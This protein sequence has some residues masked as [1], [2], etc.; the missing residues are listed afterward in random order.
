MSSQAETLRVMIS[1]I[2][3]DEL[4]VDPQ[5]PKRAQHN[6]ATANES[7]SLSAL[8]RRGVGYL[9]IRYG[10]SMILSLGN[11]FVLT[12]W[13]GPHS[14]G[15]F[16]TAVSLTTFLSSLTR[17]GVDTYLVRCDPVPDL[18]QYQIASTLVFL[19]SSI[20]LL[21]GVASIPILEIWYSQREFVFPYLVLLASIPTI[22]LSGIPMAKLERD[23]N[24]RAVAGIEMGGQFTSLA[25]A[26][27][28][29][30]LGARVW[31]PVMGFV[32]WQIFALVAACAAAK[33]WPAW[34]FDRAVARK[35]LAFG[36]GFSASVRT[37]Q[38][39]MLVNPLLVGRFVGAEGVAYVAFA[40]RI[41][42]GLGFVRSA[43]GRIA[44]AALSKLQNNREQFRASLEKALQLQVIALGPLLCAFALCGPWIVPR[45]M[46][47]RWLPGLSVYPFVAAA[48]LVNSVF[49]LQA[50]ALFVIGKQWAVMRAYT[51]HVVILGATTFLLLPKLGILGYGVAELVACLGYIFLHTSLVGFGRL[52]YRRL[53]PW[54][55]AFLVFLLPAVTQSRRGAPM[56]VAGMG[57]VAVLNRRSS[58]KGSVLPSRLEGILPIRM[59]G[60]VQ[61]LLRFAFKLQRRGISYARAIARYKLNSARYRI[62]MLRR[63]G[64]A[65][66][67]SGCSYSLPGELSFQNVS[68]ND[69]IFHFHSSEIAGIVGSIPEE[70]KTRTL[71]EADAVLK[72]SFEFRGHRET[73]VPLIDWDACPAGNRSWT[74]DLNRHTF[75]L[76]LGAAFYYTGDHRYIHELAELWQGW[77]ACNPEGS[78]NWSSPFEVAARLQNWMW[79]YFFLLHSR[80]SSCEHLDSFAQA[81]RTHAEY[82]RAH[83]EYHWPNNHLLLEAKALFEFALLF[84]ELD[85]GT[86]FAQSSRTV[87]EQEIGRQVLPDGAHAELCSMYH[88]IVAGELRELLCL[89]KRRDQSLGGDLDLKLSSMVALSE[90]M[91][92][93]DGS[94]PLL[95]DSSET[96]TYIRFDTTPPFSRDLTYWLRMSP[97]VAEEIRNIG[98]ETE[99]RLK[100]F[101]NAGY[102]FLTSGAGMREIHVTFDFG[103]FSE[104][105]AANH[106]H[107]DALSF[108]LY[109]HGRPLIVDPGVYLP[110]VDKAG[111]AR[112]F[113]STAAHNTLQIDRQ[114]QSELSPYCDVHRMARV[115]A[116]RKIASGAVVAMKAECVPYWAGEDGICHRRE[117][118][119][120]KGCIL[121][122]R[123]QVAGS[124]VHKLEWRFQF[125]PDL[126]VSENSDASLLAAFGPT[127]LLKLIPVGT[128]LPRLSLARGQTDPLQGWV[129]RNSAEVIP[130]TVAIYTLEVHLPFEVEFLIALN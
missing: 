116:L 68:R 74:W 25:V 13:I 128:Q 46:G 77:I 122:V 44:I 48:V 95:G 43:A 96:D 11:M 5:T 51:S 92:R 20:L 84:P 47:Q 91:T 37:W 63:R 113:R 9:A 24:F 109:S 82:L 121:L 32:A 102:A 67:D 69:R 115:S 27:V 124:G 80:E 130:A 19:I 117:L 119:L 56:I 17:F 118:R 23:L 90:A 64:G 8:T 76:K 30:A 14:Y 26:L 70:L 79:S 7:S 55:A 94:M 114:E 120:E 75:F 57:I 123:D 110:W 112:H 97:D 106:G 125:A 21:G 34:Q 59:R 58:R 83:L 18:R 41:A 104:C 111:W 6:P 49:N 73:L 40:V 129:S 1:P 78:A 36:F 89:L 22:G 60:G 101:P 87:L 99:A 65:A 54:L 108:E 28:L 93:S 62:D 35:M 2:S 103:A 88:K 100:L 86:S 33:T 4:R 52:S 98:T 127:E 53:V 15:L 38:L 71:G 29:A 61:H 31:A 66:C 12:W 3:G 72:H 105:I 10:L 50:S 126:Q 45:F 39:R 81:M 85:L 42:E 16:V 107:C